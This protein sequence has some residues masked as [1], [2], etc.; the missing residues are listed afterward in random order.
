MMRFAVVVVTYYPDGDVLENLRGIAESGGRLIVID[1]TPLPDMPAFQILPGTMVL[2]PGRNIGLAAALNLGI[3]RA[4]EEGYQN[5]FLFDQDSRPPRDFFSNMLLFKDDVDGQ[6][7]DC[8]LY[9]SNFYDRNTR[10]Y[11][12]FP[13]FTRWT[14]RRRTCAGFRGGLLRETVMAITSG[15][16]IAYSK[17]LQTGPFREDYFIDGVDTE[18]CLRIR[19]LGFRAALNCRATIDHA[20]GNRSIRRFLG[21]TLRPSFH[22]APRRY[23][24][25]RNGIRTALDYFSDFP[26]YL[27]LLM[28]GLAQEFLAILLYEREKAP[29]LRAMIMGLFHGL[30]SRLGECPPPRTR[31]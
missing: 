23:Y 29:K 9:A 19:T 28:A 11:G 30:I 20:P 4:G 2:K 6:T 15:T 25:A 12:R 16:L 22:A 5:I 18:Y 3:G 31:K 1:N 10:A 24:E 8:A 7:D 26:L 21:L 14:F 17:Y 27:P 13:L